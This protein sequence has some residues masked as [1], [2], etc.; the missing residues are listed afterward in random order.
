M[1]PDPGSCGAPCDGG[2]GPA[3]GPGPVREVS[4]YRDLPPPAPAA[5]G[6]TEGVATV[7][8]AHCKCWPFGFLDWEVLL[9]QLEQS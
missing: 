6:H 3:L 8:T 9:G 1:K 2:L 7:P 4:G 5:L